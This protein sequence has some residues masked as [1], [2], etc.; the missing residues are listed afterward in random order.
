[1]KPLLFAFRVLVKIGNQWVE[2]VAIGHDDETDAIEVLRIVVT[3][4]P[5]SGFTYFPPGAGRDVYQK[6]D[7]KRRGE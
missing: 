5:E 6:G 4:L 3:E 7:W 1:M 2:K